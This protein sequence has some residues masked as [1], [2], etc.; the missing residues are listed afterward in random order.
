ML[1]TTF[2]DQRQP[3]CLACT[4]CYFLHASQKSQHASGTGRRAQ[5]L[6]VSKL[7]LCGQAHARKRS[8]LQ[9]QAVPPVPYEVDD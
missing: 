4:S 3:P 2:D 8:C 7:T 5:V 9:E 1:H 6:T